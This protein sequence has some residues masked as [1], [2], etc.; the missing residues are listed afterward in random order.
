[1]KSSGV[2][3]ERREF[4]AGKKALVLLL[5]GTVLVKLNCPR[6]D[7]DYSCY[8]FPMTRTDAQFDIE[9]TSYRTQELEEHEVRRD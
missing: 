4:E 5:L 9:L 7:D 6:R 8:S 3:R 1:M 2:L